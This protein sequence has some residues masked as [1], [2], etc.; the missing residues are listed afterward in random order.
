MLLAI[1]ANAAPLRQWAFTN[2]ALLQQSG[3][4]AY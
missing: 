4:E 1:F 3:K 2:A